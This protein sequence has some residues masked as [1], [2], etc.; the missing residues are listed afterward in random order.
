MLFALE[1]DQERQEENE[2]DLNGIGRQPAVEVHSRLS[3]LGPTSLA[4]YEAL[5]EAAKAV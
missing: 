3:L 4:W 5:P 1:P 2:D